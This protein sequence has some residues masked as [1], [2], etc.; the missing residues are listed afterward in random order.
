MKL[1]KLNRAEKHFVE[2][3]TEISSFLATEPYKVTSKLDTN[4]KRR[5][6]YISSVKEI[7]ENISLTTGEIIQDLRSSLDHLAY[8]LNSGDEK[9]GKHIYFPIS[10]DA[11]QY[12]IDKIRKTKGISSEAKA[13]I[14]QTMPYKEGNN[15]LWQINELNNIDKHRLLITVGSSFQSLDLGEH[16]IAGMKDAFPDLELPK[17]ELFLKPADN[18]FPLKKGDE[19][20]I[21]GPNAKELPDMQFRFYISLNEPGVVEGEPIIELLQSM[22]DIVKSTIHS[23]DSLNIN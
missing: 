4:T 7:P 6:Y 3:K 13:K 18:L 15:K 21:D 10:K 12:E 23:F 5:I 11:A 14:D 8:A 20:F 19:L 16:M 2:L 9:S 17:I 1:A 22:L